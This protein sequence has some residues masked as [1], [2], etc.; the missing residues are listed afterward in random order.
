MS[1][2]SLAEPWLTLVGLGEDG[3]DG[4][5]PAANKALAQAALVV[6]GARHLALAAPLGC[7]TL[8]WPSPMDEAYA[9]DSGAARRDGRACWRPAIRSFTASARCWRASFRPDEMICLPA[10]SAFSLVAARLGWA[11]RIARW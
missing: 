7:E 10:P 8:A 5:S 11:S 2:T 4:L 9:A 6:G 1:A 3:R